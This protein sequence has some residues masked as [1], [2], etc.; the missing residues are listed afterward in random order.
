MPC[1]RTAL[2]ICGDDA[3][4]RIGK[5]EMR[6]FFFLNVSKDFEKRT[7]P[8]N[9]RTEPFIFY[10]RSLRPSRGTSRRSDGPAANVVVVAVKTISLVLTT[11]RR[12]HT[13]SYTRGPTPLVVLF[14]E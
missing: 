8:A 4:V 11:N 3:R 2:A 13:D 7:C 6:H 5:Y 1:V 10:V 9:R 14:D 12:Y